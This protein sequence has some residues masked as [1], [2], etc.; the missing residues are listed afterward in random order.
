MKAN[1]HH[2]PITKHARVYTYG[3][4]IDKADVVWLVAH[5][6]GY[7]S[8]KFIQRF[9]DL[10]ADKHFVIAPEALNRF[11]LNG[12]SGK[13]GASWMTTEDRENEILD[14][15]QYLDNVFLTFNLHKVRKLVVL[16]F[17]Q[18]GSTVARWFLNTK[19][20]IETLVFWGSSIPDEVLNSEKIHTAKIFTLIGDEDEFVQKDTLD[21]IMKKY[22]NVNLK[23][24]HIFYKGGHK[25]L[26]QPLMQLIDKLKLS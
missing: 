11:Y 20:P 1:V 26:T 12:L 5:G 14:Y 22:N 8:E 15:M 13:V 10:D 21:T 17:S 9:S 18:G 16:G 7:L 24:S 23:F 19:H 2:L 6:Y 25:I 4:N 3:N